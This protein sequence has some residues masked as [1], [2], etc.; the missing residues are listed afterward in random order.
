MV[1]VLS[2]E[3][4]SKALLPIDSIFF[5]MITEVIL[6]LF[7]NAF[8]SIEVTVKV[9]VP[10]VTVS[11]IVTFL[12]FISFIPANAAVCFERL[13]KVYRQFSLSYVFP[14]SAS[15]GV[16]LLPITVIVHTADFWL[17]SFAVTVIAAVPAETARTR[18][19]WLTEATDGLEDFHFTVPLMLV[20]VAFRVVLVAFLV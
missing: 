16:A 18:P 14:Y 12:R 15:G 20:L 11:G 5:P 4:P 3:H 2:F 17:P 6:F 1:T 9:L 13:V 7:F 19:L 8:F 10:M